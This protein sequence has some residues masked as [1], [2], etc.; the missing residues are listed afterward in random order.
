M[1]RY[2]NLLRIVVREK[3]RALVGGE[4]Q[5]IR[6]L[7]WPW[8]TDGLTLQVRETSVGFADE[9]EQLDEKVSELIGG[10]HSCPGGR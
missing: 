10:A 2:R 1:S 3:D 8:R 7:T 9:I 4:Y 6:R 5:R